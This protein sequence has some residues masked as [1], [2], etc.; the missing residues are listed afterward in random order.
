MKILGYKGTCTS[1]H[2]K[3][4]SGSI[5]SIVV[6]TLPYYNELKVDRKINLK[7]AVASGHTKATAQKDEDTMKNNEFVTKWV[8]DTVQEQYAEDIALVISHT[9]LRI[10]PDEETISYF[11][12]ITKRGYELAKTF[13]LD[14]EGFDIWAIPW[15]RLEH[16]AELEEYN[17]TVLADAKIL[18]AKDD[19]CANRFTALQARLQENL[20]NT[21]KMRICAL[22]AYAQAKSIYSEMLFAKNSDVKLGA[23]YVLDY[24]AQAI[25]FTNNSY[26]R[27][28]QTEQLAELQAFSDIPESF[29]EKYQQILQESNVETQKK[30]CYEQICLVQNFLENHATNTVAPATISRERNFQDLADW[31]SELSYTWLRLRHY[32]AEKDATKVYMW[33]IYLQEELNRVCEDF[34][35]EKQELMLH[36]THS[37]LKSFVNVADTIENEIRQLIL[38][39]GGTIHE[40]A[41]AEEFLHEI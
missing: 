27:K 9:T 35:L 8:L 20:Q 31:Y 32:A 21:A 1:H 33:G 6:H 22:Q 3:E 38:D 24:L 36:Y 19:A 5:C 30:L 17:L 25:V 37:D 7:R 15:E 4:Q 41:T 40:Y 29:S 2:R 13:I 39:N 12:P 18:Y 10:H 11:V 26:F 34:G 28:S 23:G 16:F 14:G